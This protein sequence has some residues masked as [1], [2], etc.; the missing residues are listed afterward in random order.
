MDVGVQ[1]A[2]EMDSGRKHREKK[3][4][5]WKNR[6]TYGK[7]WKNVGKLWNTMEKY[8]GIYNFKMDL[9]RHDWDDTED[10]KGRRWREL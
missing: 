9:S 2:W 3:G 7:L 8:M 5:I 1:A 4:N 10:K 6:E